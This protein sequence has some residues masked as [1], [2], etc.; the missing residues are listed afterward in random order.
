MK[1]VLQMFMVLTILVGLG[2]VTM[3]VKEC[4]PEDKLAVTQVALATVQ[5]GAEWMNVKVAEKC[6]PEPH[7]GWTPDDCKTWETNWPKVTDVIT[8]VLPWAIDKLWKTTTEEE[9]KVTSRDRQNVV[10]RVKYTP[11]GMGR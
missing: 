7:G 4:G 9:R 3:G 1:K 8:N 10:D 2:V 6:K 5:I 11:G